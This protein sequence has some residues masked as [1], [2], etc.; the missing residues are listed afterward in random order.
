MSRFRGY[1]LLISVVAIAGLMF[2]LALA[3]CDEDT[4]PP[5]GKDQGIQEDTGFKADVG[6]PQKD[7]KVTTDQPL[8]PDIWGPEAGGKMDLFPPKADGYKPSPFG[9][10]S[11]ADCFGQKCCATPWGVKLCAPS[12]DIQP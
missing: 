6:N 8:W 1:Q 4:N 2:S 9:C 5:V 12:C 11:D 10:T 7:Q 3:G